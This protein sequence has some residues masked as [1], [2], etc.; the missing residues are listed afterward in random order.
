MADFRWGHLLLVLHELCN[1][2][3][4]SVSLCR[5]SFLSNFGQLTFVE[6][7]VVICFLSLH[8]NEWIKEVF[9]TDCISSI[10]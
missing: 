7:G 5:F 9:V 6:L 1:L 3:I 2:F 10:V 8:T 4:E